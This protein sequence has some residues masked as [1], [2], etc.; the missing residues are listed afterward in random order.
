MKMATEYKA[1]NIPVLNLFHRNLWNCCL[2]PSRI[3]I[4][5]GLLLKKKIHQE[6]LMTEDNFVCHMVRIFRTGFQIFK[7]SNPMDKRVKMKSFV[8]YSLLLVL[9]IRFHASHYV[10]PVFGL[11]AL[12]WRIVLYCF[13]QC[14]PAKG[15]HIL[16]GRYSKNKIHTRLN[17]RFHGLPWIP[18]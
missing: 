6:I 12:A 15:K 10:S 13:C 7:H 17:R 3:R 5:W 8:K 9:T 11:S 14:S 1:S 4:N 16:S 18:D 2:L